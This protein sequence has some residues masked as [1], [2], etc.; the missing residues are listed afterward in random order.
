MEK[1]AQL[2]L[3]ETNY[4]KEDFIGV[5]VSNELEKEVGEFIDSIRGTLDN[6]ND[7]EW[8]YKNDTYESVCEELGIE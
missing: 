8:N 6:Y 5:D 4:T 7:Y 3:K 1:I 2:F